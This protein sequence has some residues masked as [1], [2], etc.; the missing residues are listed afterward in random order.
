MTDEAEKR[1]RTAAENEILNQGESPKLSYE[2]AKQELIEV[3]QQLETGEAPLSESMS[4][5]RRG[6]ELARICQT[7][8]EG[9]VKEVNETVEDE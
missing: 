4:L 2:E 5:W 9:A 1:S 7:W 3:V 8:L 6:E